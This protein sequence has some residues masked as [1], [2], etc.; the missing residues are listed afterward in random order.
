MKKANDFLK[1]DYHSSTLSSISEQ[2]NLFR[3]K[4]EASNKLRENS[5]IFL[6]NFYFKYR[7]FKKL[8]PVFSEQSTQQD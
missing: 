5:L 6:I 4:A 8:F 7:E 2:I 3:I 1:L